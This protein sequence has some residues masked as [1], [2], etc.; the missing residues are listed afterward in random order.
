[1]LVNEFLEKST[2][3]FPDKVA[4]VCQDKRTTY[5]EIE[6]ASNSLSHALIE[7]GMGRQDRAAVYLDSSLESVVSLFGIL[8]AGGIF[9]VLNPQVKARKAEYILNDC[10]VKILITDVRH[11]MEISGILSR[12]PDLG[13]IFIVDS[14]ISPAKE[15]EN[16]PQRI[17]SYLEILGGFPQHPP[18][19]KCID[20]DLASLI[21]TSGSTG[22]PKGVMCTHLNMASAASSIIEYLENIPEDIILDVLP[23][24]F[25][26]GLYQILMSTKFG[27]TVVL[28]KTFLYPYRIIDLLINE[29]ITGFPIVP[30]IAAILLK[31][32]NLANYEFPALRYITN[33]A[34]AL[35]PRFIAELANVFPAAKIYSMYGLTECKRVSYLS[36]DDLKER[37]TSVGKAMP[38]TEAY[39]VDEQ[40]NRI[41]QPG[42]IGE[43]VVR[44][45]NV[46]KGYWN[47]PKETDSVFRPGSIPGEKVLFTGDLFKKDKEGF[48]YFVARKDDMIKVGGERVS[49]KEIENV[50][51]NIEG[52]NEAAV[53]GVA[54]EILGQ[55]VKAFISLKK[56]CF[57]SSDDILWHCAKNMESFMVPKYVEVVEELPKSSHGK[58]AKKELK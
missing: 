31:L 11:L 9:L 19:R 12:C 28:E 8:K 20:I 24:S 58:I 43:L 21:Y 38:N 49:P 7:E 22:V 51:H 46:M 34:Q 6:Q 32:K 40:E 54:D 39:I 3:K 2:E 55:A 44:G 29:S 26:Y 14:E 27:G 45:A 15:L 57:L 53:I 48:L 56:D 47:L 5:L 10:Q 13:S 17:V 52:V 37:P 41:D 4:V 1:M 25:D 16:I 36:P 23:I 18:P 50:L 30:T 33:T 35:P 42:V